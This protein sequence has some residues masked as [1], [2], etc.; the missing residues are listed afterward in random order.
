MPQALNLAEAYNTVSIE[1]L[2]EE[3]EVENA[4][5]NLRNAYDRTLNEEHIKRLITIHDKKRAR[6]RSMEDPIG[7]DLLFSLT[8]VEYEGEEGRWCDVNPILLPL[9]ETWKKE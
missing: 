1:Q 7:R 9:V 2:K 6:D 3:E 5:E 8:A 4:L